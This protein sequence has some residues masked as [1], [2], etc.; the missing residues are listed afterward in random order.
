M[1]SNSRLKDDGPQTLRRKD[2]EGC[3][4]SE[5]SR[6]VQEKHANFTWQLDLLLCRGISIPKLRIVQMLPFNF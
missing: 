4:A 2:P 1:E 6:S 3:K 5:E